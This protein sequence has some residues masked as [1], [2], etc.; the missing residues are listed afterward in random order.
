MQPLP[1][2]RKA[3][4]SGA[5]TPAVFTAPEGEENK[6][7]ELQVLIV[8]DMRSVL[9]NQ[10]PKSARFISWWEPSDEERSQIIKGAAIRLEILGATHINP[11]RIEVGSDID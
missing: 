10:P 9:L 7:G 5:G 1:I 3:L 4:E 11:M 6:V 8:E 2:P